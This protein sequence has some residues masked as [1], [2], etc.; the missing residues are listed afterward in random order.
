MRTQPRIPLGHFLYVRAV[1]ELGNGQVEDALKYAEESI[2]LVRASHWHIGE[3]LILTGVG[4]IYCALGRHADA[5]RCVQECEAITAG[6]DAPLVEFNAR[7]V[8]AEIA[9]RTGTQQD[10]A[11]ALADAFSVGRRQGYANTFHSGSRLLQALLP[12]ALR[13]G[14]EESY[15]CWVIR[16]RSFKAPSL[17][18][19]H[20]PWPVRIKV[21]G[22]LEITVG[23]EPLSFT[24]K[25]QRKPLDLL[26]LL[27]CNPRGV[28]AARALDALW[29]ELEGDRARN[30]LDITLHRLRKIL[31]HRESVALI[32]GRLSIDRERVWVDAFALD[33]LSKQ[34]LPLERA[35]NVVEML[36]ELYR[37][38]LLATDHGIAPLA[39]ERERIRHQF[40]RT[41]LHFAEALSR[42][43]QWP[44]HTQ[45]C[46]QALD[47]E[48]LEERL[49]QEL[50]A[51][52]LKRGQSGQAQLASQRCKDA[53]AQRLARPPAADTR[54]FVNR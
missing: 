14:I 52:L 9:L 44:L 17:D 1:F 40:V 29:P 3:A 33:Q 22:H 24:G 39:T 21:L 37:G 13:L 8:Q 48:P 53:L 27:A 32:D 23:G 11:K 31:G 43:A 34:P 18:D 7:L 5:A 46:Q 25:T 42:G 41:V 26:K 50:I 2:R 30:A 20:W 19:P 16:K 4:E 35:Q 36:L 49:Y 6:L 54:R 15:C 10:L 38:P 45:L 51:G 12:H 47:R 28:D